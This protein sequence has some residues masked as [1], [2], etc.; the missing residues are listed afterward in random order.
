ML[1]KHIIVDFDGVLYS[2]KKVTESAYKKAA[3][4]LDVEFPP[5]FWQSLDGAKFEHIFLKY[6]PDKAHLT[7]QII[8]KK[9]IMYNQ[10][11][12][13]VERNSGL[14]SWLQQIQPITHFSLVSNARRETVYAVLNYFRDETFFDTILTAEDLPK[15]KPDPSGFFLA[16]ERS[17][18]AKNQTLILEDSE[19]GIQ[20]CVN[21]GIP[22]IHTLFT[23]HT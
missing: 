2:T 11:L 6:F 17:G 12:Q 19:I 13:D 18:I 23:G 21:S 5:E 14:F 4:E 22:F 3:A 20:A 15:L 10:H 8:A 7:G 16:C 1:L 9:V